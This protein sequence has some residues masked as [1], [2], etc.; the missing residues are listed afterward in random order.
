MARMGARSRQRAFPL[1]KG[2]SAAAQGH[3]Y[4]PCHHRDSAIGIVATGGVVCGFLQHGK[5]QPLRR[6]KREPERDTR[7]PESAARCGAPRPD[8]AGRP[9][10]HGPRPITEAVEGDGPRRN[11][12]G[13]ITLGRLAGKSGSLVAPGDGVRAVTP[14]QK[15]NLTSLFCLRSSSPAGNPKGRNPLAR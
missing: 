9:R 13:D 14:G 10:K 7:H 1:G 3:G 15:S 8:R 2:V 5:Q 4:G 11:G 6:H 12:A